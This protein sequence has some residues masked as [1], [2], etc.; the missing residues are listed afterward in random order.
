MKPARVRR[1]IALLLAAVAIV[2]IVAF[3]RARRSRNWVQVSTP[4]IGNYESA[5]HVGQ[6][7]SFWVS[8]LGPCGIEFAV[9]WFECRA[10]RERTL[11]ATNQLA[12]TFTLSAGR[13][14]NLTMDVRAIVG[15]EERPLACYGVFW[16]EGEPT[17]HRWAETLDPPANWLL[18]YLGTK[19]TPPW[20]RWTAHI[21]GWAWG[22]NIG[23]ADYFRQ[24]YGLTRERWLEE[25]PLM[26]L[27][28]T[29]AIHRV[30]GFPVSTPP[31]T[32]EDEA[33]RH[34]TSVFFT[35]YESFTNVAPEAE[36]GAAPS[37]RAGQ[38]YSQTVGGRR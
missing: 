29:G 32:P 6:G 10:E 25:L 22:G 4:V 27:A 35:F 5:G 19:W 17:W 28:R 37:R 38:G 2:M 24:M 36:P 8:N 13:S 16:W 33:R 15:S 14:T 3:G 23:A 21:G 11:L 7:I 30:H 26:E 18:D 12:E 34:A 31:R 20:H 1:R 9:G